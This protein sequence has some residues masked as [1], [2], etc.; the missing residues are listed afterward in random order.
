MLHCNTNFI[1]QVSYACTDDFARV[2]TSHRHKI[3]SRFAQGTALLAL[4]GPTG[5]CGQRFSAAR[6]ASVN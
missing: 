4:A 1:W 5:S 3:V 2:L 6:P